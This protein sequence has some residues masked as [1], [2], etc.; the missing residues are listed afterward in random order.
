M[1][2]PPVSVLVIVARRLGDVLLATP[3]IRS[4]KRAWPDAAVDVLVFDGTQAILAANPDVRRVLTVPERPGILKHL[5]FILRLLRRYDVALST[6]H[7]D[8]PTLY[9]FLAGRWRAGLLM[10]TQKESWKQ[11]LLHAWAPFDN[12]GTHTVSM[13]LVLAGLLGIEQQREIVVSWG[14]EHAARVDALLASGSQGPIAVLH[15]Y[16]KFNYKMWHRPGWIE[17][18][19]WLAARG[20]RIVLSGGPDADETAYVADIARDMPPGTLNLAGKLSLGEVGC[21]ISRAVVF[22][23]PDTALTHMAAALGIPTIAI[24]GPTNPVKWGPWPGEYTSTANPW[25]RLGSQTVGNVTLLQGNAPCAP[26]HEEGC[27]RNVQSFSDCLLQLPA[28][29][30]IAAL[31]TSMRNPQ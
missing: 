29:A 27:E 21:L 3:L 20:H 30:V 31:A 10:Q 7:G 19:R 9:A 1:K 12:W 25:K 8:R 15:P 28:E 18:A 6:Q 17:V 13:N 24:Y 22:V 23:G 5:A 2:T 11:S 16:P 26:C 14:R 4:V